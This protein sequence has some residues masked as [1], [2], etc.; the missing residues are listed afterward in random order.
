[1]KAMRALHLPEIQI[2]RIRAILETTAGMVEIGGTF[3]GAERLF[4]VQDLVAAGFD[5]A[6]ID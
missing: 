1:M 4:S 6:N 2:A 3:S 5:E